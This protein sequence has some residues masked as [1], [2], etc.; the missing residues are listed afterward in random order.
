MGLLGGKQLPP[1]SG[2]CPGSTPD[3]TWD[4]PRN[5][6][7][8]LEP[9]R[10]SGTKS[11]AQLADLADTQAGRT[12][13]QSQCVLAREAAPR[14]RWAAVCQVRRRGSLHRRLAPAMDESPAAHVDQRMIRREATQPISVIIIPQSTSMYIRMT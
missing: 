13:P 8:K 4:T 14:R 5:A 3:P 11:T 10:S 9:E 7:Q 2:N 12:P 6:R 1:I